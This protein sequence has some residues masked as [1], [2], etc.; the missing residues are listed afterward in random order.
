MCCKFFLTLD[1]AFAALDEMPCNEDENI[2]FVI[3]SHYCHYCQNIAV[4]SGEEILDENDF[5]GLLKFTRRTR[6]VI[7]AL[8]DVNK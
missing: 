7:C 6:K 8:V 1:E 3:I 4:V 2:D 5:T